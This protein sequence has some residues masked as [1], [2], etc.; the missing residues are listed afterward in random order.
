MGQNKALMKI[1]G[2]R[3]IDRIISEFAP[4]SEEMLLIANDREVYEDC[5]VILLEDEAEYKGHGPLAG[6]LTGLSAAKE[7]PCLVIACDMPFSSVQLGL[8]LIKELVENKLDAVVPVTNGQMH[9]LFAA[10]DAVIV[11][12]VKETLNEGKRSMKA[13]LDQLNVEFLQVDK[14]SA[15]VWNMNTIEDYIEAVEMAERSGHDEL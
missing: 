8:E 12:L 11:D 6:L 10:Y 3:V 7:G 1:G 13:L 14:E 5:P 4:V 15:A 9:P 2:S